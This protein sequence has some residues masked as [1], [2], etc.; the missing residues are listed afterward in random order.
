LLVLW[1]LAACGGGGVD[2]ASFKEATEPTLGFTIGYPE[3]WVSQASEGSV[4]IATS[5]ELFDNPQNVDEGAILIIT[6][7]DRSMIGTLS[8]EDVNVDDPVALLTVFSEMALSGDETATVREEAKAVTLNEHPAAQM[9][10]DAKAD[11]GR[12]MFGQLTAVPNENAIIY[13]FAA[14]PKAQE[15]E[16]AAIFEAMYGTIELSTPNLAAAGE[17]VAAAGDTAVE[18]TAPEPTAEPTATAVP[19]NT[20]A[21]SPTP[22]PTATPEPTEAPDTTADFTET[23]A[24]EIG[25]AISHPDDWVSELAENGDLRVVSD[26]ALLDDPESVDEGVML[27][28]TN[29]PL[30]MLAFVVPPDADVNDPVA[31]LNAFIG[32]IQSTEGEDSASTFT[33]R[34]AATAVTIAGYDA[35]VALYEVESDNLDGLVKF[36]A[37]SDPD[38]NRVAFLLAATPLASEVDYLPVIDAMLETIALSEPTASM[39]GLPPMGDPINQWASS[40]TASSEYSNPSWSAMQTVGEPDT[41]E[42]GDQVTAWASATSNGVDWLEVTFD[43]PVY[44]TQINIHQTYNPDQVVL[45]E[46]ITPEGEAVSVYEMTPFDFTSS[47]PY[48]LPVFADG[49]TVAVGVRIHVDQSVLGL[50]WNEI[51]AV[52]LIGIPVE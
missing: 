5:Q 13:I 24:E 50:G 2:T 6:G 26:P 10:V 28:V 47:C 1:A 21:P 45:V 18:E 44:A 49:S 31:V 32:I 3:D 42:C 20:P 15:E 17:E 52:E 48:V 16:M 25:F 12:E 29:L 51:D 41:P 37:I 27:Q 19:T 4:Q 39:G 14:T 35:A 11:D 7:F 23:T 46:L 40:A 36:V 9:S 30:D 8:G 34:D 22:E 33:E 43:Q 38:N